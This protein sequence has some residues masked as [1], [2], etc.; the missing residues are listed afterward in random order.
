MIRLI[1]FDID[2]TLIGTGGAGTEA[3]NRTFEEM[4]GISNG[5][6]HV[7]CAGKTDPQIIREG[8]TTHGINT[9]ARFM[10]DFFDIYPRHLEVTVCERKG[11][12]KPGVR[13]LLERLHE[14]NGFHSALLTGNWEEGARIKLEK[15]SLNHFF[16]FGAYG[17]D[18][19]DRNQLLPAAIAK[20]KKH[21]A[22]ELLPSECLLIGDTPRDVECAKV[23][24]ALCIAVATGPYPLELLRS[25]EADLVMENLVDDD[26]IM[27]WVG[28]R[29]VE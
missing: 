7:N 1:L 18:H 24:G 12:V 14:S 13:N 9:H 21:H 25:T 27:E 29:Q 28:Q 20:F 26:R 22:T 10:A 16:P 2:G 4:T 5:F 15:F 6:N 8:A 3:M 19:E 17:S 11:H 23:H